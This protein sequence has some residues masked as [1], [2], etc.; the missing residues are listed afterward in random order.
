MKQYKQLNLNVSR[1][2]EIYGF[3]K[4]CMEDLGA[5]TIKMKATNEVIGRFEKKNTHTTMDRDD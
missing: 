1:Q 3:T 4:F 2:M 5:E